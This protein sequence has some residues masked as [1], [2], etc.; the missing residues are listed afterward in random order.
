MIEIYNETIVDLLNKDAK[1]L[2]LKTAGNK[3]NLPGLTEVDIKTLDD[4]KKVMAQGD[5]NR[6]TAST[7]MNSTR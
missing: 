1:V 2:D 4:I 5:K 3:V 7:K 6:S